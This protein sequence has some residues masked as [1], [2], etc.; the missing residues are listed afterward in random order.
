MMRH[1]QR[2][3]FVAILTL[4]L[5]L[6]LCAD[7]EFQRYFQ[8]AKQFEVPLQEETPPWAQREDAP[9]CRVAWLSD[10]H[11]TDANSLEINR[12]AFKYIRENPPD[13]IF[14]TGDNCG[15]PKNFPGMD[16]KLPVPLA[17]QHFLKALLE[18]ELPGLPVMIIPGDNWPGAFHQ[19]FGSMTYSI[20][21]GGWHVVFL[22]PDQT[23]YKDGCAK[24]N[25]ETWSW[26]END[27]QQHKNMPTMV[28]Q[29]FTV[30]PPSSLE[31]TRLTALLKKHPQC[32]AVLGGHLHL[33]LEFPMQGY[34]QWVA[35]AV[36]RS[37]RPG[38]KVLEFYPDQLLA[39]SCE[40][41]PDQ[42][43]FTVVKKYQRISIPE[44]FSP[45]KRDATLTYAGKMPPKPQ[46]ITPE[47]D[48]HFP[49]IK[50]QMKNAALKFGLMRLM[51]Q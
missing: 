10:L 43:Q 28:V 31:A 4:L 7:D 35:P 39:R 34:T 40:L 46:E 36:G 32:L 15:V 9:Y 24:F 14:I 19:C 6:T 21:L 49:T 2:I 23:G 33:D 30:V 16:Q 18:K 12:K 13:A 51:G 22:T 25:Q 47:L 37:H 42:Q 29:H 5:A 26:L 17:R 1:H 45:E 44:Q 8:M 27:L 3:H 38:F 50:Q 20:N 41:T 11:I 48:R